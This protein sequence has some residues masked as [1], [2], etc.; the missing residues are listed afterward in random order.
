MKKLQFLTIAL[1]LI[2]ATTLTSCSTN[3][4]R[5]NKGQYGIF[6]VEDGGGSAVIEDGVI[7]S[8]SLKHFQRMM[9]DNP[10]ITR[11][12]IQQLPGSEDDETNVLLGREIYNA[13]LHIH[14][15]DNGMVA[16]GGTDLFLAGTTRTIGANTQIGVHSWSDGNNQATDY[17]EDAT[18]HQMFLDYYEAIGYSETWSHDFYFFTINAATAD[19]I[20]WMTEEEIEEYGMLTE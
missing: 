1:L 6:K 2:A 19:G 5:P 12:N 15:L 11:I 13:N 18:E 16:S 20:H 10:D 7:G 3:S 4:F 8:K 14:I 9:E 17:A